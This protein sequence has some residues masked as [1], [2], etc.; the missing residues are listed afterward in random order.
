MFWLLF[1]LLVPVVSLALVVT[2]DGP[3]PGGDVLPGPTG[4]SWL[5]ARLSRLKTWHAVTALVLTALVLVGAA[6]HEP[7]PFLVLAGAVVL[8]LAARAWRR[9]LVLLMALPDESFPGRHDKLAWLVLLVALPPLGVAGF[10]AYRVAHL[11]GIDAW[12]ADAAAAAA[13]AKPAP[14]PDGPLA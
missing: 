3:P 12:L 14:L 8:G 11:P 1:V 9:E 10:R 4:L 6:S 5:D 2:L 7:E 13:R